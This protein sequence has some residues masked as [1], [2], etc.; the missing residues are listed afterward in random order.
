M[1]VVSFPK[2]FIVT[3]L[4]YLRSTCYHYWRSGWGNPPKFY[5]VGKLSENLPFV[6]KFSSKM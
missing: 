1:F 6:R 2:F 5:V 3:L 4:N